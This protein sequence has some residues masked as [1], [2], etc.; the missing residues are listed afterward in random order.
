VRNPLAA[1]A[2]CIA[3]CLADYLA[4]AWR[5]QLLTGGLKYRLAFRDAMAVNV[6]GDAACALSPLRI[7]GEPARLGVLLSAGV[8]ATASF[9]A[10][11]YEVLAAWPVILVFAG[12][13]LWRYAP[14]WLESAAP[15]LAEAIRGAWPWVALI[16]VLTL[17]AWIV[18]RRSAPSA[19]HHLGRPLGRIRVH[20]RRM[21]WL[22]LLATAPLTLINLASRVAIL[23]VLAST[24]PD[25]PPLGLTLVGSFGLLYSQL[26]LPTPSGAGAV[27][28]G[29]LGGAAG[30][31]GSREGILLL[32]WRFYTTGIG[33]VT[34]MLLAAHRFGW[35]RLQTWIAVP[36]TEQPYRRST[37]YT[38][39]RKE[40]RE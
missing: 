18:V 13:L 14:A 26:I 6:I 10:I 27:E 9:V 16:V 11:T 7:A 30:N 21:P 19:S 4:R 24:L 34:G 1:H 22:L 29:F 31:L 5:L 3:L 37:E 17:A 39:E 20:W 2:V 36:G 38:K 28:F 33:L 8:P 40:L 12:V 23:P 25:P 35:R 15:A 32:A